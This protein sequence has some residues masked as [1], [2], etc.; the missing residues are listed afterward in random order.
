MMNTTSL[1][2]EISTY[3]ILSGELKAQ[4]SEIDDE[5]LADTLEGISRL[6]D[7]I[8]AITRSSLEDGAYAEAL[9]ARMGEMGERLS[10]LRFRQEKKRELVL[11]AMEKAGMERHQ[12]AEFS[13]FLRSNPP[14]LEVDEAEKIPGEFFVPQ[15]S[16]LDRAGL[17]AA[18]KRGDPVCGA[19]LE[20]AERGLTVR[21]K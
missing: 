3:L 16:R 10:R 7:L 21:V 14:R 8:E 1:R 17:I 12:A 18:L 6:P 13:L 11:W 20:P 9:K 19:H 4:Y 2:N 5:T 15:P